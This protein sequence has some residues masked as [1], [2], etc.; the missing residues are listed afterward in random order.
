MHLKSIPIEQNIWVCKV[1]Q[2]H[3]STI[4]DCWSI[5]WYDVF[6]QIKLLR[7]QEGFNGDGIL[8]TCLKEL[9]L[10]ERG[11]TCTP[12]NSHKIYDSQWLS[13]YISKWIDSN[14]P[15]IL[16]IINVTTL[17]NRNPGINYTRLDIMIWDKRCRL[18]C[19]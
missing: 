13:I 5:P 15:S 16:D 12:F 6:L 11:M 8:M 17:E 7:M 19:L 18:N 14:V 3:T 1:F 9:E 10:M 4:W 2:S